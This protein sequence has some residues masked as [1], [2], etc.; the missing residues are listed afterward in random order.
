[1]I[2]LTFENIIVVKL[3]E[4][5]VTCC[6]LAVHLGRTTDIDNHCVFSN[7]VV[8]ERRAQKYLSSDLIT[9]SFLLQRTAWL[10]S[11][12]HYENAV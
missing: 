8:L 6:D 12:K 11:Q 4:S 2:E 3:F 1:M 9:L 7:S 10:H 5:L